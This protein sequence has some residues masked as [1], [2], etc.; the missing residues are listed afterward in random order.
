MLR[1][2]GRNYYL[3]LAIFWTVI[4]V[5]LSLINMNTVQ[6]QVWSIPNEDKIV[7]FLFYFFFVWFWYKANTKTS[8]LKIVISAIVFGIIIEVFQGLF[9]ANRQADLLD[10]LA[11]TCGAVTAMLI[12][13]YK[14]K[15][16]S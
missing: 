14:Q 12:F 1:L 4:I 15:R 6:A 5:C 2:S 9:T 11:N 3:L 13:K 10:V 8:L 7:H 16:L